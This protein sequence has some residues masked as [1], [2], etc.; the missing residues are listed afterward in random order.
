MSISPQFKKKIKQQQGFKCLI[1]LQVY[2]ESELEIHHIVFRKNSGTNERHN[3]C[4]ISKEYHK[5]L[6]RF[7]IFF[8]GL[9]IKRQAKLIKNLYGGQLCLPLELQFS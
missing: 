7:P 9:V 4:A 5:L 2:P 3:L 6:H 8:T 1:S